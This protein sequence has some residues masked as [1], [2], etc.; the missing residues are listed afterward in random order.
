MTHDPPRDS[1]LRFSD[2]VEN[3][4][5][6]RPRYPPRVLDVLR[7]ETGF[8]ST[9]II[10]DIGS[11]TGISSELFLENGNTVYAVEP[12]A[13]MRSAAESL[14]AR[15]SRFHS[16]DGTAEATTLPPNSVNYVVAAQAYHWFD[17][18]RA[19]TEFARVL[20]PNGWL[21]LLWNSSRTDSTALL[22][23]YETLLQNF[24]TDYLAVNHKNLSP[25]KL[26]PI[27][28]DG[29]FRLRTIDNAQDFDFT[30]L[31]GRLLSSSYAPSQ[32]HPNHDRMLAELKGIF[33]KHAVN[34]QV[35]FEYD[36]EI[37]IGHLA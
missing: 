1:T 23:D 22:R 5:N 7:D 4:V 2:R 29:S 37:Y 25:A 9:A 36:L 14:L 8:D 26:A 30:G 18:D 28:A 17:P 3:Y 35:R 27:F 19:K 20:R 6:F 13:P 21:V 33:D 10:A 32:T 34:R 31:K 12:N 16:I 24:A 15:F 11:G